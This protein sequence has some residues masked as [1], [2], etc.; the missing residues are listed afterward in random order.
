MKT[1]LPILFAL[2]LPI[3][4]FAQ[5]QVL[6]PSP[7]IE[8]ILVTADVFEQTLDNTPSSITLITS[9]LANARQATH[10]EQII[11]IAPNVNFSAGA[12]R[13]RFIQI[14]GIGERSQFSEPVNPSVA[15]VLDDIDFSGIGGMA[16]MLDL[17]QVEI[18]AGPQSIVNGASGL[19]GVVKML[20]KQPTARFT[21]DAGLSLAQ[22]NTSTLDAAVA[23]AIG[24]KVNARAA[25]MQ[26]KTDGF[27][28]NDYLNRSDTNGLDEFSA[29]LAF[30]VF[31]AN[32]SEIKARYYR[33]DNN[34]AYD[35][36]SLDNDQVTLSD[37]PGFDRTLANAGSV[38]WHTQTGNMDLKLTASTLHA[39]LDYGYDEDWTFQGFHPF[40]YS[41]FDRYTR[42]LSQNTL[43]AHLSQ[44]KRES[45]WALGAYYKSAKQGL[46]REYT[47]NSQDFTSS[48]EP[49]SIALY[50]QHH[51]D[52]TPAVR[53]I[54]SAR[55]ENFTA[56]YRDN[57]GFTES[58]DDTLIALNL[59]VQY[60]YE[61]HTWF[62]SLSRGYKAGGFNPDQRV[63]DSARLYAPEY[64]WNIELGL[65]K[66]LERGNLRF[67]AFYMRRDDAQVS[68]FAVLP[69]DSQVG[70]VEFID[71]IGNADTGVNKGIEL[72]SSWQIN[73]RFE[74]LAN[75]GYLRATFGDYSKSNGDYVFKQDQAQAPKF[76]LYLR[77]QFSISESLTWAIELESKSDY[78]F[79]DGHNERSDAYQMINSDLRWQND[80]WV[81]SLWA[82]N[83]TDEIIQTRGFGG[84]SNDPRDAYAFAEPYY[85]FGQAR[86]FGVSMEYQF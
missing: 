61:E 50:A 28:V 49:S 33:I 77:P 14:R 29:K 36:F 45:Q 10:L 9:E 86:Q 23:G 42:E 40:E 4:L 72:Q 46:R 81:F 62:S 12:S 20:G 38:A 73:D 37:E 80:H 44:Q 85:Q 41:S 64:N 39:D 82:K 66:T 48:Y 2:S 47:Y 35:A 56:D 15:L 83:L 18:L 60:A 16:N 58:L 43:N 71:V 11:A 19:G 34:N 67:T 13:G 24:D 59:S 30:D 52:W 5:E 21:A 69:N 32:N 54:S 8:R 51:F 7:D 6:E 70:S 84:F 31:L 74:L 75:L 78:R 3:N 68:D 17:A 79:S 63:S 1:K 76:T 53:V 57:S 22:Y 26:H 65:D 55:L 27:V 25:L